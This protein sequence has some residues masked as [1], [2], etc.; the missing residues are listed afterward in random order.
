MAIPTSH[1]DNN[2]GGNKSLSA[3]LVGVWRRALTV[4]S[5]ALGGLLLLYW[6]TAYSLV[7]SWSRSETYS[8][9]FL[10]VPLCLYLAWG[11]RAT[12]LE[13]LPKPDGRGVPVLWM[14]AILWLLGHLAS[15]ELVEQ[16]T[17]I[18][19]VPVLVWTLLGSKVFRSMAVPLGFLSFAVPFGD[20]L[21]P[22]LQDFT[23]AFTVRALEL[24][25][26][27]VYWEGRFLEVPTGRWEVSE[28]CSGM[29]Y[30]IA[31]VVFGFVYADMTYRHWGR[32]L[33]FVLMAA[34]APIL[35]NGV[36]AYLIVV[37]A[38][39]SSNR[40]AVGVDHFIY[41]WFFFGIL[42]I[43][44]VL[45][46]LLWRESPA[47]E[48][49]EQSTSKW[50]ARPIRSAGAYYSVPR[51]V[52][53]FSLS[54]LA[55]AAGPVGTAVLADHTPRSMPIS[56]ELL[57]SAVGPSWAA[58]ESYDGGWKP[59]FNGVAAEIQE[60]F[61]DGI[62]PVHMYLGCYAQQ[63]NSAEMVSSQ[64]LL[65]DRRKWHWVG[66]KTYRMTV[67]GQAIKVNA[68]LLRGTSASRV[69]MSWYWIDGT[70]TGNPVSAKLM[71]VKTRLVSQTSQGV[72]VAMAADYYASPDE[73]TDAIERFMRSFSLSSMLKALSQV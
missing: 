19:M 28:S 20:S 63:R 3:E 67:D 73:A 69:V 47:K 40:L 8:H 27:P 50:V 54:L 49:K 17:F 51:A 31:S 12:A 16:V 29:R 53:V 64:N 59:K 5:L 46:G 62:R 2:E 72:A 37:I 38:Y 4:A 52:A 18:T 25:G 24:T 30:I 44:M 43:V 60:T 66:E 70:F 39:L 9:G 1:T 13:T 22:P 65:F 14:L 42:I 21:V 55:L 41:G 71:Q 58:V 56:R 68:V 32:R 33:G 15:V 23:T 7:L 11:R 61:T 26:I 57:R 48:Q 35:A 10:I 34:L 6:E 45:T 36:R